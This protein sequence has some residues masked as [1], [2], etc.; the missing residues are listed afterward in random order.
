MKLGIEKRAMIIMKGGRRQTT[1]GIELPNQERIRMLGEKENCIYLGILKADTIKSR[2]DRKNNKSTSDEQKTSRK[3][4]LRK[5]TH[6]RN[7]HLGSSPCKIF[8]TLLEIDKGRSQINR[9]KDKKV[10][11]EAQALTSE[12]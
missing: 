1:E 8:G 7:K 2:D 6:Q 3:Q 11:S 12:R 9:P 10:D 5:K 4:V